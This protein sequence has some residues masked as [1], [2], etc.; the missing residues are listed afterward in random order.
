MLQVSYLVELLAALQLN[1]LVLA[2]RKFEVVLGHLQTGLQLPQLLVFGVK[3][4]QEMISVLRQGQEPVD[5]FLEPL[6]FL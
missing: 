1:L 3:L 2:L 5:L 6:D 4:Y